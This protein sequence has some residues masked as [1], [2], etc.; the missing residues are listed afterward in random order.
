[1]STPLLFF[2]VDVIGF[3]AV[4]VFG[5]R[6]LVTSPKQLNARLIALICFNSA[7][8]IVLARQDYA[9]WI[10]DAYQLH[11]G[12]LRL[13]LHVAR[14]LT[15]GLLMILCFSLF[16][17][18]SHLPGWLVGA[19]ALQ[20][21]MEFVGAMRF[22][23]GTTSQ[24]DFFRAVP[25]LFQLLFVAYAL[26]WLL[27]GWRADLVEARRR[28]RWIF[29]IVVGTFIFTDILLERLF[30]PWD[31]IAAFYVHIAL[32]ILQTVLAVVALLTMFRSGEPAYIDPF[33][34]EK[35]SG[36]RAEAKF[37]SPVSVHESTIAALQRAFAEQHVYRD[38][39]LTVA[40][41]AVKLAVPEYRLRKLVHE[42]MGYRNFN[43]LLHHYR[44]AE[45]CRNLSDPTKNSLPILTIALTVGYNSIN[46]FNRAF[47]DAKGMT[48]STYRAQAQGR[49]PI[50]P[51]DNLA[52][53]SEN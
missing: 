29:L 16:Q 22:V 41:L 52:P 7:C 11:V 28:L 31:S 18:E 53:N 13:P 8:A 34:G 44:I 33:G 26:F 17:D 15:P 51:M 45:A 32:S 6:V 20:V 40:S 21:L 48:P 2:A 23:D 14:N 9:F 39:D 49:S 35:L 10:P 38:G 19:F 12:M 24:H 47:R 30:I 37:I 43:A 5:L 25:A 46:P 42:Q 36:H 50:P 27:R 3:F 4:L 1:M